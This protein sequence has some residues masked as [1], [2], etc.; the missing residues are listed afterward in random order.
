M[1]AQFELQIAT[2]DDFLIEKKPFVTKTGKTTSTT[3]GKLASEVEF[4]SI[5]N[6]SGLSCDFKNLYSVHNLGPPEPPFF[7]PGD[8]GSGVYLN[9]EN[10]ECYKALGIAFA[11]MYDE[12]LV[13]TLVCKIGAIVN[14][15]NIYVNPDQEPMELE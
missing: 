8:S 2:E 9:G 5:P 13:E 11:Y 6:R 14:A 3:R 7:E 4:I 15:F 10:D 1:P 12:E